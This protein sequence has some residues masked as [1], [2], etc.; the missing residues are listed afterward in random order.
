MIERAVDYAL[1]LAS[2]KQDSCRS[3]VRSWDFFALRIPF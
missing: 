1:S 3:P 2:K